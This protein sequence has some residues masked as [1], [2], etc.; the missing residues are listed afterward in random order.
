MIIYGA[1]AVHLKSAQSKNTICPSCNTQG[2]SVISIYRKHAHIFWIPLFPISK[3]GISQ[4]QHCKKVLEPKEMP[5]PIKREY[6]NL[7]NDAKG[8][9]WQ[10]VGLGIIA[11]LISWGFYANAEDK[12]KES[13]YLQSPQTGDIYS[14][15]VEGGHYSTFKIMSVTQDSIF[16]SPN[17]YEINKIGRVHTIDKPENYSEILYGMSRIKVK[18]MYESGEIYGINR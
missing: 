15:K 2:S 8:P 9:V 5:E 1:R 13:A 7:K 11:A 12:K 6:V 10:F 14:Y 17:Q 18:E 16:I 4:C 3:N